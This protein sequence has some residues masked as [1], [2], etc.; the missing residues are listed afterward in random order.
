[1]SDT[2]I[3]ALA[4]RRIDAEGVDNPRF[5]SRNIPTVRNRLAEL[6]ARE[7]AVA[8]V[9]SGACGAD[10][11][12]LEKAE[13]ITFA[14]ELFFHSCGKNFGRRRLSIGLENGD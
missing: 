12:G 9:S 8:L 13:R 2:A 6:F 5:D 11:I 14:A 10:L 1:M 3:V 4:G 7:K